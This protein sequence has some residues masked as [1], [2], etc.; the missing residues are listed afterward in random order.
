MKLLP[1]H[2]LDD[3]PPSQ[4][5]YH[6]HPV[7]NGAKIVVHSDADG[8]FNITF[9]APAAA[10]TGTLLTTAAI[11]AN[12]QSGCGNCLLMLMPTATLL[13]NCLRQCNQ[14]DAKDLQ[15][16]LGRMLTNH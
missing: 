9:T 8:I 1:T 4:T 14:D 2:I 13:R 3:P 5:K 16:N 15:P 7:D 10:P 11:T 12:E 6:F